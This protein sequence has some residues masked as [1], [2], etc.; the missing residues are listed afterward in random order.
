MKNVVFI[1]IC[2]GAFFSCSQEG[3]VY[4]ENKELS[5][6][7]VWSKSDSREFKVPIDNINMTY[8]LSVS[9]RYAEGY[10]FDVLRINIKEITPSGIEQNTS[11]DLKIREANGEYIGEAGFDI[12]D[13]EHLIQSELKYEETG[14]YTYIIEHDMPTDPLNYSMEIG[15]ILD[16]SK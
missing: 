9:F 13:S 11:H 6:E 3:R 1:I 15:L 12:W 4:S 10:I 14:T 2:I 7:V 16:K 8:D 5:P